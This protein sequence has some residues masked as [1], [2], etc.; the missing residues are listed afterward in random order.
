[1]TN[2]KE[3]RNNLARVEGDAIILPNIRVDREIGEEPSVLKIPNHEGFSTPK[4]FAQKNANG[5]FCPVNS[6]AD[7]AEKA[8]SSANR[9][10]LLF[11]GD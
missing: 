2:Q 11:N 10:K 6:L 3:E 8:E 4:S 9:L 1:M 5:F 7:I